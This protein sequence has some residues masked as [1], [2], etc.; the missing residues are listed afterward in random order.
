MCLFAVLSLRE[1]LN[2]RPKEKRA[3]IEIEIFS[4]II[5]LFF[6]MNNYDGN[7]NY[8][9]LD[10]R[11]IASLILIDL[12]PLV[13]VGPKHKYSLMN[14]L[15]LIGS[16]LFIGTTFNLIV[17]FRCYDLDYVIYIFLIAFFTDLFGFIT[18][19][20]IGKHKLTNIS[21]KKTIE[22]VIGGSFIGTFVPALF[23][24]STIGE[25]EALFVVIIVTLFLSIL[26]QIGDL[27]F[28]CIKREFDK[29]DFSNFVAGNGGILDIM[30]SLIFIT[31]GLL[32]V[33]AII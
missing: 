24:M 29:K 28:S 30:D 17:Q 5:I 9:F 10:Y 27:V 8:Y 19:R 15:Y 32:L 20:L 3:P 22:G 26:G 1:M 18:G 11:L 14:A 33:L 25:G 4:Y 2:I 21:P 16:T 31:L 7:F 13:V 23:F 12:I 6:V